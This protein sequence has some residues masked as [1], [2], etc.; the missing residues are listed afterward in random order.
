MKTNKSFLRAIGSAFFC[1]MALCTATQATTLVD[2]STALTNADPTELG[3]LSRDGVP[4]EW[5]TNK[6]YPGSVN[7][8]TSFHYRTF[9]LSSA[10]LTLTP[11]VQVS[12][13]DPGA[14]LFAAAYLDTFDPSNLATNYLGDLGSSGLSFG[15]DPGFFQIM[16]PS[17]HNLVLVI[18]DTS[19]TA[20]GVGESFHL[21]V[22]GFSD[23][24]YTDPSAPTPTP[25][26]TVTPTATPTVTP[27]ATPTPTA[28]ASATPT[29]TAVPA[30]Q[31]QPMNLSTRLFVGTNERVGIGGFIISGAAPKRLI[32]RALGPSLAS[33]GLGPL[34]QD[35][36]LELHGPNGGKTIMNDNWRDTQQTAIKQTKI[37]PTDDR[38]SAIVVT[39]APGAYTAIIRGHHGE[40]GIGMIE[41]Y[42]LSPSS[43]SKLVNLS[44]RADVETG[45]NIAIAGVIIAGSSGSDRIVVR[46]LG[47]SLKSSGIAAALANPVLELRDANGF[48]IRVDHDWQDDAAQA[49]EISADGLAPKNP[50]ESAIA[51]NLTPGLYT[52]LLSGLDDSTGIGLIEIYHLGPSTP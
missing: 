28:T 16:V 2:T 47:P 23:T 39:L 26:P 33:A 46:G 19:S 43:S 20:A 50:R 13:D 5:S 14:S 1:L 4:S 17:G 22:E 8:A 3:R 10:M 36:V 21:F 42:D 6:T 12:V 30:S 25:T 9:S 45:D 52:V 41:I 38:E 48:L 15:V 34:L 18:Q 49:A 37:A 51:E 27:T 35:P 11:Y 31:P 24:L 29:A 44:T 40:T 7:T 32:I